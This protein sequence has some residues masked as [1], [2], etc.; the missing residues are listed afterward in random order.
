MSE[1]RTTASRKPAPDAPVVDGDAAAS[2][3]VGAAV[4]ADA[5][6]LAAEVKSL[7][8]QLLRR[9]AEFQNYRRRTESELAV[10]R[11]QG[12]GE[13]VETMLDVYDDLKRS[14]DAAEVAAQDDESAGVAF[15][16]LLQG[17]ELVFRKFTDALGA[18]GVEKIA[19]VGEPFDETLHEAMLQQPADGDGVASGT[20]I[21][22]LQ[23][24]YRMGDRVLRHA[25]VVVAQ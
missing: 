11:T 12:R 17:V 15:D 6:R 18:L 22:E 4:D 19:A 14:L 8:D 3:A 25:R 9:A 23:P 7:Q 10:A 1:P 2:D 20:V 16:A 13:A 21:A 24:G 5:E